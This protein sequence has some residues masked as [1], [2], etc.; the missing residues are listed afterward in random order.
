MY[1]TRSVGSC[2]KR[3]RRSVGQSPGPFCGL[4]SGPVRN[5]TWLAMYSTTAVE[6]IS[7][8]L[9]GPTRLWSENSGEP[10]PVCCFTLRRRTPAG[11]APA[12]PDRMYSNLAVG[13]YSMGDEVVVQRL[14]GALPLSYGAPSSNCAGG[15]RT[16]NTRVM[17]HVLRTGSRPLVSNQKPNEVLTETTTYVDVVPVGSWAANQD[18]PTK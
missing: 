1:S 13:L 10:L 6:R 9:Q 8:C 11:L 17:S 15:N 7:Y 4:S 12:L 14:Y 16:H 18:P 3:T 5:R 2:F